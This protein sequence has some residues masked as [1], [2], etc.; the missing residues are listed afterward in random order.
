MVEVSEKKS[1]LEN[2]RPS[3][4]KTTSLVTDLQRSSQ[5]VTLRTGHGLHYIILWGQG[6]GARAEGA[7]VTFS[8]SILG[9]EKYMGLKVSS[10]MIFLHNTS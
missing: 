5:L 4:L 2:F 7:V 10:E 3:A 9:K 8:S 1:M 6:R